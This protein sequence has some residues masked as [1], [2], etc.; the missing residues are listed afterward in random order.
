MADDELKNDDRWRDQLT[1]TE[2]AICRE[3]HT[4]RPFTGQYWNEKTEGMYTCRCCGANL[5]DSET[6][7]DSGSGWPSFYQGVDTKAI[8]EALDESHGMSRTEITCSRC[9]SHLGH[10]FTDGP[11]PTGLRYCVNSASLM[12]KDHSKK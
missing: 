10:V 5:F 4:E 8:N 12:L 9:N 2:Y 3:G 7:Y 6:K 11:S 1:P